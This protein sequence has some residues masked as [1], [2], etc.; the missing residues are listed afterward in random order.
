MFKKIFSGFVSATTIAWSVGA[1]AL[2]LPSVASAATAGD[3]VKASGPAVYYYHTDGKRYVF[4]NE[5]TYFSWFKDFSSV[6]TISDSE[7]ASIF[8][9]GNVTVRPGTYLAKV[10]TDPKVYAVSHDGKFHWIESEAIAKALYGDN[11]AQRVIDVPDA[12]FINYTDGASISTAVHPDGTVVSKDGS[13]WVIASGKARMIASDAVFASNGYNAAFT[14]PTTIAYTADS[15]VT[16]REGRLAD[17]IYGAGTPVSGN[18]TVALASDT[19]AGMTVPNNASSVML[20]KYNFTAGSTDAMVTGLRIRRV[21]VGATSDLA[22]VYLYDANGTRLTTGRTINSQ[23]NEVEF[24]GLNIAISAGQTKALVVSGDFAGSAILATGGQHSF[25]VI[26]SSAVISGGVV[27]GAFPVAGNVFTVGTI[28]AGR[29]DIQKGTTPTNP[30]LGASEAEISNFKL[31]ANTNDIEVRRITLLQAGSISSSDLTN[32]KLYTGATLVAS[33]ASLA[34]DKIVLNFTT[35]YIITNGTTKTFSLKANVAGRTGRTI[36]TY[37]EYTTDIYAVDKLYNSGAS[38]CIN[39][40]GGCV[41][42]SAAFDGTGAD[43]IEVLTQGGAL[44]IAYNGPATANIA[45]GTQDVVLFKFSI[46]NSESD[47]EVRDVDFTIESLAGDV[48]AGGVEFFRDIKIKDLDTGL[49]WM[50]PVSYPAGIVNGDTFVDIT[51]SDSRVIPAGKTMNLAI[52][53][54]LANSVDA[55]FIDEQYRVVL[56]D[57]AEIFDAADVRV[58]STSEFLAVSKI[59]PNSSITGNYMTVKESSLTVAL[60]AS[61][62]A[63]IAVKKQQMIPTAGF[64]LSAGAQSDVTVRSVKLSGRGDN[65]GNYEVADL[66]EVVTACDLYDG[67]TK[68]G[69][70]QSI[71][72]LTGQIQ[73]SNMDV[74]IAQGTSKTLVVKCTADSTVDQ[75]GGDNFAVGIALPADIVAEDGDS[76]SITPTLTAGVS[77]NAGAAPTLAQ[78]VKNGGVVTIAADNLRQSTILVADGTTWQNVAS[79]KATAQYEEVTIDRVRVI[80]TGDSASFSSVAIAQNGA[81]KGEDVLSAGMNQSKDIVLSTPI[82]VPKDGSTTF[83]IWTKIANVE[84]YASNEA[85]S[86]IARSGATVQA[87]IEYNVQ[88]GEW[89][90]AYAGDLNVRLIGSASGDR[91]YAASGANINGNSFVVRKTKPTV[92]R[93]ALSSTTLVDGSND[94]YK[95]QI[96]ADAAGSVAVKKLT[97][98]VTNSGVDL[99]N[100]RIR[101]GSTDIN[102]NDVVIT[103]EAGNDLEGVALYGGS[104]VIVSFVNEETISGA[105][106]VYTLAANVAGAG[107]GD[108]VSASLT[109]DLAQPIVS[110]YITAGAF[111]GFEGPNL[112]AVPYATIAAAGASDTVGHFIWSDN[113]EVPHSAALST[114][115]DWTNDT[116]VED[117]TQSQTLTR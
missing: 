3:L 26:D 107:S 46:N 37:V 58:N 32:F 30:T 19:P 95:L 91:L 69:T 112:D 70:T 9:G 18:I 45:K 56:G 20:A 109:R 73:I 59:I 15:S 1:G 106:S 75:V 24:N 82:I 80:G 7:L 61:P 51:L 16:A 4:P 22:N 33:T 68:V 114:S 48:K 113:S 111:G 21:G 110:G 62:S 27:S 88:V 92:T 79:Y 74:K 6:K 85:T 14:I 13:K 25:Q 84:G 43:Y 31:T 93:Q 115:R 50:G 57:G 66:A 12:F 87:G 49:T 38:V 47:V 52:T 117:L 98:T 53:A 36:R 96:S 100:F 39:N 40:D 8:V 78:N 42:S 89:D 41:G 103:D 5:K 63:S 108:S 116:Y 10:T 99:N 65:T 35:P 2:A 101:K 72:T 60:A 90:A 71:D 29:L 11:W 94:L 64:V 54:D 77:G 28:Q 76:N 44:S 83:Q 86:G 102:I 97:F 67:A 17:V 81:V 23:T 105:G 34:G 55:N 104:N